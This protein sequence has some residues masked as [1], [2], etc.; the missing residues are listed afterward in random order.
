MHCY[1]NTGSYPAQLFADFPYDNEQEFQ[2]LACSSD[3]IIDLI[4]TQL[5]FLDPDQ[6]IITL[7]IG[8]ND[9]GFGEV[10][11]KCV[12]RMYGP[13]NLEPQCNEAI[14]KAYKV[15]NNDLEPNLR[16]AWNLMF[17]ALPNSYTRVVFQQFY[18]NFFDATTDVSKQRDITL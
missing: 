11:K 8:G 18:P 5:P 9:I 3:K 17:G 10:L 16:F 15:I 13:G 1:R 6:Q 2:F 12:L 14:D 7:S 4:E